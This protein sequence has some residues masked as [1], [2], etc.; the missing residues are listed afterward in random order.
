VV[1]NYHF[2]N[3]ENLAASMEDVFRHGE[4]NGVIKNLHVKL[5]CEVLI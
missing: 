4:L 1:E 2:S 5:T 3:T